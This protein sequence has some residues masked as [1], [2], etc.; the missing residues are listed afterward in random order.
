MDI[1]G[2]LETFFSEFERGILEDIFD[3]RSDFWPLQ[4]TLWPPPDLPIFI[5]L[6]VQS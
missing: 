1:E 4:G 3:F 6:I 5:N 2:E